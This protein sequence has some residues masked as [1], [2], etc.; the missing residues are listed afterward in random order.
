MQS[1][2]HRSEADRAFGARVAQTCKDLRGWVVE[3]EAWEWPGT[4]DMPCGEERWNNREQVLAEYSISPL[5]SLNDTIDGYW[6]SLPKEIVLAH[7]KRMDEIQEA[8]DRL[9]MEGLKSHVKSVHILPKLNSDRQTNEFVSFRV[10]TV[11][12]FTAL[13]TATVLEALPYMSWLTRL[14]NEWSVRLLVCRKVPVFVSGLDDMKHQL[15]IAAE[16]M[17]YHNLDCHSSV[18]TIRNQFD[19]LQKILG[20]KISALGQRL[21]NMLDE[22]E[23][24]SETLPDQWID[25]FEALELTYGDWTV[26]SERAITALAWEFGLPSS[27]PSLEMSDVLGIATA[28]SD[29]TGSFKKD[30][31]ASHSAA[32]T[33]LSSR[34]ESPTLGDYCEQFSTTNTTDSVSNDLDFLRT[35]DEISLLER[36]GDVLESRPTTPSRAAR[37]LT[38][39]L[40]PAGISSVDPNPMQAFDHVNIFSSKFEMQSD[41]ATSPSRHG[42]DMTLM[43]ISAA[44]SKKGSNTGL[45]SSKSTTLTDTENCA[46]EKK[47]WS[48]KEVVVFDDNSGLDSFRFNSPSFPQVWSYPTSESRIDA[49][50]SAMGCDAFEQMFVN[51]LADPVF[52]VKSPDVNALDSFFGGSSNTPSQNGRITSTRFSGNDNKHSFSPFDASNDV[53]SEI[54]TPALSS[55][56]TSTH[57]RDVSNDSSRNFSSPHSRPLTLSCLPTFAS[58]GSKSVARKPLPLSKDFETIRE[59]VRQYT[60]H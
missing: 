46:D 17:S 14:L 23:G 57:S 2:E 22:L 20:S 34:V 13:V 40:D 36:T 48:D 58:F 49:Q 39:H 60:L 51:N 5:D 37:L 25:Q 4:F 45:E 42:S 31:R 3:V 29:I 18:N 19:S 30:Q 44:S 54:S 47:D 15:E 50:T 12:D 38:D 16:E 7:E 1:A 27:S 41:I 59:D 24:R 53:I 28:G 56:T 32:E 10:G 9:D 52:D 8:M 26:K 43:G 6:G 21:D 35:V 11:D 33:Q 55:C